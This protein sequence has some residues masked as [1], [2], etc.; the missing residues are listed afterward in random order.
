MNIA[1]PNVKNALVLAAL[2]LMAT[3]CSVDASLTNT[4]LEIPPVVILEKPGGAEFVSGAT[5]SYQNSMGSLPETASLANR[6]KVQASV[7]HYLGSPVQETPVR[8]YKVYSSVQGSMLSP[9]TP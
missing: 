7:G 4:N 8:H 6:Y 2:A 3:G 1:I 5:G 9:D